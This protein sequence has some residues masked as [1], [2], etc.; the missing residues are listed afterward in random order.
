MRTAW[1]LARLPDGSCPCAPDDSS[2]YVTRQIARQAGEQLFVTQAHA[3][4]LFPISRCRRRHSPRTDSEQPSPHANR[5][6]SA[7]WRHEPEV[8]AKGNRYNKKVSNAHLRRLKPM[9]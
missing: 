8:L 1:A 5:S 2:A 7:F 6:S 4:Q 9:S 3:F